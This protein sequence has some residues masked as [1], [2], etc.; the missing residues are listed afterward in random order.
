VKSFGVCWL[1][2]ALA[3]AFG[4]DRPQLVW[5]GEVEGTATLFITRQHL[6]IE[7]KGGFKVREQ[8]FHFNHP[9][10][11][12]PVTVRLEKLEGRGYVQIL[13]QPRADNDYTLAVSI[14][15]RQSGSAPY[16]LAFYWDTSSEP[17]EKSRNASRGGRLT[18]KGRVDDEVVVSCH[19]NTCETKA[20]SGRPVLHESFRFSRP[21][22]ES[23][24]EVSLEKT[25]GRGE[26]R[27]LEPP[28]E[29]NGYTARVLIRDRENGA[30]DYTFTLAWTRPAIADG[31]PAAQLG[32]VWKGHVDGLVR[33]SI[34]GGAAFSEAM[35]GKPV[36]G[37][38]VNLYQPLPS[39]TGPTATLRKLSGRGQARITE[40]PSAQ[41]HFALIFEID[42]RGVGAE[43][44]QIEVDW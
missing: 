4:Q 42:S 26:I 29:K 35:E 8:Q 12:T 15:D 7:E 24:V 38:S 36:T 11:D 41:N 43:D 33:V 39:R 31:G 5:Q 13:E 23:E 17:L 37:E 3:P 32:L 14:E 19:Q 25:D 9:L 20:T 22:P 40:F 27:L 1:V 6:G 44:Y 10:P 18:W 28:E 34:R 16:S 2:L 21:L 30:S